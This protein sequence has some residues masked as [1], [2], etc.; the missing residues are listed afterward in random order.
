MNSIDFIIGALIVNAMPHL[1]FGLTKTHF[2]GLF[3][4]SPK[5]NIAYAILQF[6]LSLVLLYI[7]Y[8]YKE[9]LHNGFLIGGITVLVLYFMFGKFMLSYYQKQN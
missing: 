8:D 7:K 2:L 3:G 6:I 5:G 4:Y 9:V 1:I